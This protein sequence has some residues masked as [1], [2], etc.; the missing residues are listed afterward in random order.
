[1]RERSAPVASYFIDAKLRCHLDGKSLEDLRESIAS[2]LLTRLDAESLVDRDSI[3]VSQLRIVPG[4]S[5]SAPSADEVDM[6]VR[7][8]VFD[9]Q[10]QNDLGGCVK[11]ILQELDPNSAVKLRVNPFYSLRGAELISSVASNSE[12][13]IEGAEWFR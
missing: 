6:H 11:V 13:V 8:N 4:A 5:S 1:M 2:R 3:F 7:L 12:I 9:N 10:N